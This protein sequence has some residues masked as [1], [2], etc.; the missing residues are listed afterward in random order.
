MALRRGDQENFLVD[1]D[2][3]DKGKIKALVHFNRNGYVFVSDRTDGTLFSADKFNP[4]VNWSER[5][6][7]ET[8]R[9]A[10]N[11]DKSPYD[12][13]KVYKDV[14]P[15]VMGGPQYRSGC[16]FARDRVLLCSCE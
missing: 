14:C 15:S 7:V 9:P 16:L 10:K 1:L 5:I 12:Y 4:N 6:D 2:I 8:G 11:K 3:P 13:H